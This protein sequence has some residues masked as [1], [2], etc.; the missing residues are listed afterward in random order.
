MLLDILQSCAVIILALAGGFVGSSFARRQRAWWLLGFF[1]PLLPIVFIGVA[2]RSYP[3]SLDVPFCWLAAGRVQFAW[4]ALCA[5]V[6]MSTLLGR[7]PQSRLRPLTRIFTLLFIL[8]TCVMPFLMPALQRG[9]ISRL[10][11]Q[12]DHDGVCLQSTDYT[13]GP[14]AAVT[15]L[16]AVGIHA[17]EREIALL[18]HTSRSTGTDPAVL[19]SVLRA[20]YAGRQITFTYRSFNSAA[21]LPTDRPT[22]AIIEYGFLVDHFVTVLK[23]DKG[24]LTI[25]DPLRGRTTQPFAEFEREWRHVGIV[26]G[27]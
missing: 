9:E 25:G 19:A 10:K 18:S 24:R 15:A 27:R 21:D 7:L 3:L 16:R 4:M 11:T 5:S 20:Q 23:S 2:R 1:L 12:I 6:L 26:L 13:C 17:D 14:A 22:I 8:Q